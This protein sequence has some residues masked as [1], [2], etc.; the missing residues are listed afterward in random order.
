[1]LKIY[2]TSIYC[3]VFYNSDLNC[4]ETKWHG[5][6]CFGDDL[7]RILREIINQLKKYRIGTVLADAR[8]MRII[9]PDDRKWIMDVWYPAAMEAGFNRQA[10]II[11]KDSF[12]EH[13][14]KQILTVY[15]YTKVTTSIFREYEPAVEWVKTGKRYKDMIEAFK[16]RK[17]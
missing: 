13:S 1:M 11:E 5:Q 9:K 8:Q 12:N 7:K 4:I 3:D 14:I 10:L 16:L 17:V 6:Y 15:D 2:F